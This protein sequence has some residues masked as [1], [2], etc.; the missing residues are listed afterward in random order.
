MET[1]K[2]AVLCLLLELILWPVFLSA[3][4]LAIDTGFA[5]N[6]VQ[7]TDFGFGDDGILDLAV[8]ADG[9]VVAVG[10][11]NNGAVKNISVARYLTTGKLDSGF[12]NDGL[13]TVSLGSGDSSGLAVRIQEDGSI[14]VAG[15][16]VDSNNSLLVLRLNSNG[17]LDPTFGDDGVF[18]WATGSDAIGAGDLVVGP[19][20]D[21]TVGGTA[22]SVGGKSY[23]LVGRLS[24]AGKSVNAFGDSGLVKIE[25]GYDFQLNALAL[26]ESGKL[27]GGGSIT[28]GTTAQA[29]AFALDTNGNLDIG[30]GSSG[31]LTLTKDASPSTIAD[32]VVQDNVVHLVG[33]S[34]EETARKSIIARISTAGVID[35]SFGTAGV[36][37]A[38]LSETNQAE[39]VAVNS[40]GLLFAAGVATTETN[41]DLFLLTLET[42]GKT[43]ASPT[44][45]Y[46][47]TDVANTVDEGRAITV[48]SDG[49]VA[50]AGLTY[51]ASNSDFAVL[52]YTT[53][54]TTDTTSS[55]TVTTNTTNTD[56][57]IVTTA[58]SK[59]TR[60]SA[61]T[62]GT[63]YGPNQDSCATTCSAQCGSPS[64]DGYSTCYSTCTGACVEPVTITKRGVVYGVETQPTY[65]VETTDSSSTTTDTTDTTTDNTTDTTTTNSSTSD[66]SSSIFTSSSSD[67]R[68]SIF[69]EG[70]RNTWELVKSGQTDDGS[71][72]GNYTSKIDAIT[73]DKTYY[74][75]AYALLSDNTVIYGNELVFTTSDACF[76]ATA[77]YG[78]LWKQPV[79]VLREFRDKVLMTTA[80]GEKMIGAYYHLSPSLAAQIAG[81]PFWQ[82]VVRCLL[83]PLVIFCY[84][85]LHV[86]III[87]L[88]FL[89]GICLLVCAGIGRILG[90]RTMVKV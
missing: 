19:N 20:G 69:P 7:I 82:A 52:A 48:L 56:Y 10:Y 84:V 81:K 77:A 78:S 67:S 63:I 36:Y 37:Q 88:G 14:L 2:I 25:P 31:I 76:I 4:T 73:P 64:A 34:G 70:N 39:A 57:R 54:A 9:K 13:Y 15:S 12:N 23:A 85:L 59:V 74:V 41:K 16:A 29:M 44:V 66:S 40:D 47:V 18:R 26:T 86:V 80:F 83:T 22:K 11:S 38:T 89:S 32:L 42:T 75:R 71:G 17:F 6:G 87:K 51:N 21:I 46:A 27:L 49:R 79:R 43:S 65:T 30:F 72:L 8:Q 68:K 24:G 61:E 53:K 1:R 33:W 35:E 3:A 28:P 55:T 5:V 60:V 58:I 45:S 62:G 90:K 50:A